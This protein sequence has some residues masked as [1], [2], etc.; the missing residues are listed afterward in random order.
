MNKKVMIGIAIVA[1]LIYLSYIGG[2]QRGKKELR[3]P[4]FNQ[5]EFDSL[6]AAIKAREGIIDSLRNDSR[7]LA[8]SAAYYKGRVGE[9]DTI[10]LRAKANRDAIRDSLNVWTSTERVRF[11]TE[12]YE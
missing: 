5:E 7:A 12:R 1:L 8:D 9:R 11:F 6:K 2:Y 4:R 10:Y 3:S